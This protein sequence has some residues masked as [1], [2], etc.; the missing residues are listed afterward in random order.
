MVTVLGWQ[1]DLADPQAQEAVFHEMQ[2]GLPGPP[3]EYLGTSALFDYS[4]ID[5]QWLVQGLDELTQK[6]PCVFRYYVFQLLTNQF[7]YG[8]GGP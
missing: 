6:H 2:A 5:Y 4:S 8:R 1:I 3:H 7:R